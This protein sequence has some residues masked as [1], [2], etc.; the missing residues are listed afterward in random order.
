MTSAT[1]DK[2]IVRDYFNAQGFD[3]WSRIYGD[4]QVN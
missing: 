3:R 4:G 2:T 1:D